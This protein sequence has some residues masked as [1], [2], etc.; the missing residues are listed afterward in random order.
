MYKDNN[1]STEDLYYKKLLMSFISD[2]GYLR[3]GVPSKKADQ[4]RLY[5]LIDIQLLMEASSQEERKVIFGK[6][7]KLLAFLSSLFPSMMYSF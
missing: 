7:W 4:R 6:F 5:H 3:G 2:L 1:L